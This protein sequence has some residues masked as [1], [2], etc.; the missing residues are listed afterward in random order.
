[1]SL[2]VELSRGEELAV[3]GALFAPNFL[4]SSI[5][6]GVQVVEMNV[7]GSELTRSSVHIRT[8][9]TVGEVVPASLGFVGEEDVGS[10]LPSEPAGHLVSEGE[11]VL[12]G[13]FVHPMVKRAVAVGAMDV[14]VAWE[15]SLEAGEHT[16]ER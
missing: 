5:L 10:V 11:D 9:S 15:L 16:V 6:V 12:C 8:V 3:I 13:F 14:D 2:F 1:M 4:R 7:L